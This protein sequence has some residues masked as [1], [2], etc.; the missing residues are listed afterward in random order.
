MSDINIPH[1]FTRKEPGKADATYWRMVIPGSLRAMFGRTAVKVSLAKVP[2]ADLS[3]KAAQ[4]TERYTAEIKRLKA[5]P[6]EHRNGA[7]GRKLRDELGGAVKAI[8]SEAGPVTATEV[9]GAHDLTAF[10]S[11][12]KAGFRDTFRAMVEEMGGPV[13][14]LRQ[15]GAVAR[16]LSSL[17]ASGAVTIE[18]VEAMTPEARARYFALTPAERA[19]L[20][21]RGDAFLSGVRGD[22]TGEQARLAP[23]LKAFGLSAGGTSSDA[24]TITALLD[25]WLSARGQRVTSQ[26]A[27]R[28]HIKRFLTYTG[29]DVPAAS[30]SKRNVSEFVAALQ[31][32]KLSPVTIQ[33][34]LKTL[35]ALFNWAVR[36]GYLEIDPTTSIDMP[37]D[38]RDEGE[39][40]RGLSGVE[41]RK[42]LALASG[43]TGLAIEILAHTGMRRLEL[44][45][46]MPDELAETSGGLLY[47]DIKD[48][49]RRILKDKKSD[50]RRPSR[51]MIPVPACLVDRLRALK[52]SLPAG[53]KYLVPLGRRQA[54][55]DRAEK[56]TKAFSDLLTEADIETAQKQRKDIEA[57]KLPADT[58]LTAGKVV[59]HSLRHGWTTAA[60]RAG[61]PGS[62]ALAIV[63]HA[64]KE[65]AHSGYGEQLRREPATLADS[66]NKVDVLALTDC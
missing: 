3:K 66:M 53:A 63:G 18:D 7:I 40:V 21:Q 52:A 39:T 31:A 33:H 11:L 9:K 35:G 23:V 13:E 64:E 28:G 27:Y 45:G 5:L 22:L 34:H 43:E 25:K 48:N 15:A 61:I 30:V 26:Q 17:P 42:V 32:A 37:L 41:L 55:E 50:K 19:K 10:L 54:A 12:A 1:V 62:H 58:K 29:G 51:R 60:R 38:D 4:L 49:V 6:P 20:A 36:N 57:G 14:V 44:A 8:M 59:L 24:V 46:I 56:I 2:A 65:G 16:D 47:L